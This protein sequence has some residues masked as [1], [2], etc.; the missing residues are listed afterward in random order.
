MDTASLHRRAR[1]A[2][3]NPLVYWLVRAV[4]QPFF[5]LYFRLSRIGREHIPEGPVIFAANHRSFLDPFVIGTCVRRPVYYVAKR[6]LFASRWIGWFLNSLGAFP[7]ERG[8]GDA[9]AIETAKELLARGDSVVIFPEGTRTRPGPLG[10]PRRG[11]GRLALEAGV[12]VVPVAVIGTEAIR[13]G[14][15]FRPHK[16][17]LRVG[18]PLTFPAVEE[19]SPRIAAA[20]TERIWACVALQWEWLGGTPPLR[21]ATVVGGGL[22]G[23]RARAL[24]ERA[25]LEVTAVAPQARIDSDDADLVCFAGHHRDLARILRARMGDVPAGAGTLVVAEGADAPALEAGPRT[26]VLA[27]GER[28]ELSCPDRAFA[29]QLAPVLEAADPAPAAPTAAPAR[30]RAA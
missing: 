23:A 4:I 20:V 19:V 11:V 2:G 18:R 25:G 5:H 10:A 29:R 30:R 27:L 22:A 6:E 9:S 1:E 16:V 28:P 21:R 13:N 15:R 24:L 26:A 12:P 14:W 8:A 3:V 17:R 7:V